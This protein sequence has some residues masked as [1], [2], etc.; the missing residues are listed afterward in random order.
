MIRGLRHRKWAVLIGFVAVASAIGIAVRSKP[1]AQQAEAAM[2]DRT[3]RRHGDRLSLPQGGS[4][5]AALK[6]VRVQRAVLAGDIQVVGS[7]A[8]AEDHYA[9][10][11]PS[12]SGRIVH[13]RVGVGDSV[14]KGQ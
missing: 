12:V 9:V 10:V 4:S 5:G 8:P 3:E 1:T 2:P 14:R 6:T 13:F 11:G 7:V